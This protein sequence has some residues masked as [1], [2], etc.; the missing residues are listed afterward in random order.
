MLS[1][2]ARVCCL[3]RFGGRNLFVNLNINIAVP[4]AHAT[5][6]HNQ[7]QSPVVYCHWSLLTHVTKKDSQAEWQHMAVK[8]C[9]NCLAVGCYARVERR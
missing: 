9:T 5:P 3:P 2:N 8:V 6:G 1:P 7:Q 4:S